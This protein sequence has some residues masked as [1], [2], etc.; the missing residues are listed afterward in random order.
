MKDSNTPKTP[1]THTEWLYRI[2]S[3]KNSF[4]KIFFLGGNGRMK[5]EIECSS[6]LV[7]FFVRS[8]VFPVNDSVGCTDADIFSK[9][10]QKKKLKFT[11]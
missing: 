2:F 10:F 8:F 1:N 7:I 11:A 6:N 3:G 4:P 9:F 5:G